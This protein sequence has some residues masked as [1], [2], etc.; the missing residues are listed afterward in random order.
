MNCIKHNEIIHCVEK[1]FHHRGYSCTKEVEIGDRRVDLECDHGYI[2]VK[3]TCKDFT[4]NRSH[5][6]VC[7]MLHRAEKEHKPISVYA[8]Q[9]C[10]IPLNEHACEFLKKHE[11]PRCT[12]SFPCCELE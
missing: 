4:S 2:E 12:S 8:P 11:L 7:E 3:A 5:E 9:G 1:D 10:Y 6:Q